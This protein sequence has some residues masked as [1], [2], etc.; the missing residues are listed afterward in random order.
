MANLGETKENAL[1][2][3]SDLKTSHWIDIYT[4]AVFLEFNVYNANTGLFSLVTLLTEWLPSGGVFYYQSIE[5]VFL[6]RYTGAGG[7]MAIFTECLCAL[8]TLIVLIREIIELF[9]QRGSYFKN[10]WNILQLTVISLVIAAFAMYIYRTMWTIYSV[11]YMMNN[12]GKDS[13]YIFC[14]II[15]LFLNFIHFTIKTSRS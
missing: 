2:V 12:L 10:P 6:Y 4:R 14:F 1:Q 7:L 11:E 15:Q 13:R 9:Q 3:L 5:T 8:I